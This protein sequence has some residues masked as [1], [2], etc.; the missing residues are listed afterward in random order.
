M[1][2]EDV[3]KPK[4][5]YKKN[6]NT[7]IIKQI[8]EKLNLLIEEN[9]NLKNEITIIN[10]KYDDLVLLTNSIGGGHSEKKIQKKPD[11]NNVLQNN[12][13]NV[14]GF[15]DYPGYIYAYKNNMYDYIHNDVI[16]IGFHTSF[17]D[18]EPMLNDF[19]IEK[20]NIVFC[21]QVTEL[22]KWALIFKYLLKEHLFYDNMV[23]INNADFDIIKINFTNIYE[24]LLTEPLKTADVYNSALQHKFEFINID[25]NKSVSNKVFNNFN[26][27]TIFTIIHKYINIK[28]TVGHVYCYHI[29]PFN[30]YDTN[31]F[32]FDIHT[33]NTKTEFVDSYA[34]FID[35]EIEFKINLVV[36]SRL[37]S[38]IIILL[39]LYHF[40]GFYNFGYHFYFICNVD[41][42]KN[43]NDDLVFYNNKYV[44][45][46][47]NNE[48]DTYT[49]VNI[50]NQIFV[51]LN[52]VGDSFKSGII[53]IVSGIKKF[54]KVSYK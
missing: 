25:F 23:I 2:S 36:S 42:L 51:K 10:K 50:V 21:I 43:I 11:N 17:K 26:E 53:D 19:Y 32:R 7:E 22:V 41:L 48:H 46:H 24:T 18:F 54:K 49:I 15:V 20:I 5:V 30:F 40:N 27:K 6:N 44:A 38:V 33:N 8:N 4:R 1:L 28:N 31:L 45:I 12:V 35:R 3:K 39:H 47:S 29:E 16:K 52:I 37:L 34:K 14:E 13:I 9:A